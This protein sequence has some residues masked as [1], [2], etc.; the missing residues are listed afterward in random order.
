[1]NVHWYLRVSRVY[2]GVKCQ[3]FSDHSR[4]FKHSSFFFNKN[5]DEFI[6]IKHKLGTK[7]QRDWTWTL[8]D[9]KTSISEDQEDC[10]QSVVKSNKITL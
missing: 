1:M 8:E 2:I 9:L 7:S 10:V 6:D 4:S 5:K 3:G